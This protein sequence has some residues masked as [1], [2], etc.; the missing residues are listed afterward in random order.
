[1]TKCTIYKGRDN[2]I[3]N[4][5]NKQKTIFNAQKLKVN[6]HF[7]PEIVELYQLSPPH[8][9]YFKMIPTILKC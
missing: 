7:D 5:C 4:I 1:L 9:Q 2:P 3:K 6:I 8:H